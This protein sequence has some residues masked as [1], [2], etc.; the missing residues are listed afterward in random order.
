MGK[1]NKKNKKLKFWNSEKILSLSAMIVSIGTF[2]LFAYQTDLIR[3]QQRMSVYPYLQFANYHNYSL[4]YKFVLTNKGIG[5]ALIKS[6]KID[7]NGRIIDKDLATYLGENVEK[8][9]DRIDFTSSNVFKGMLIAQNESIEIVKLDSLNNISSSERL[10]NL[11]HNDSLN[12]I[13]EYE[14]I[15]GEKW[16]ISIK[17]YMPEKIDE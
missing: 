13:I 7:I 2:F 16:R 12:F 8:S 1:K 9:K 3:K 14:S 5:P 10:F 15:Y 17:D 6:A 4:N 11:I